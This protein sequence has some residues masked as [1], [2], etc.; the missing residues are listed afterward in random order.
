MEAWKQDTECSDKMDYKCFH[1]ALFRVVHKWCINLDVIEYAGFIS[2][3][4]KRVTMRRV[5]GPDRD[6][7]TIE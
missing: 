4:Y 2:M 5:F 1:K 6:G 7:K 3:L